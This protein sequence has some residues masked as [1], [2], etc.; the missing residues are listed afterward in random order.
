MSYE[1]AFK[2]YQTPDRYEQAIYRHSQQVRW[3][4]VLTCPCVNSITSQPQLNCTLC[5]GRGKIFKNP[6]PFYI[7]Q[8]AVRHD[9]RGRVWP[10]KAPIVVG[11]AACWKRTVAQTLASPQ[12]TDGTYVQLAA[13]Y[14]RP[15]EP[16]F[17]DYK[18]S[19][20]I[21]VSKENSTVYA[22]NTL[23][24]TAPRFN[25]R[26]KA[27]EGSINSVTT[28]YNLTRKLTYTVTSFLKEFIYL[29]A[30]ASWQAS[31]VLEVTYTYLPPFNFMINS[32]SAQRRYEAGY[33]LDKAD[34]TI[35][36]PY[37]AQIAPNDL[38]TS[39]SAEIPAFAVVDPTYH[40]GN[41]EIS[42]Y[43]DLSRITNCISA[44]GTEYTIGT[45]LELRGRNEIKWLTTKPTVKYTVHFM[46]HPTFV[47]L[48]TYD[49]ARS[50]ESK[51]FVNRV[52][53]MMYDKV[54]REVNF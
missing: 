35:A 50:S 38:I 51:S 1:Q 54:T 45:N 28:V 25:Y 14:I 39:L 17:I 46:Y 44:A 27:F 31:D 49:T 2:T 18:F 9:Y 16:L 26:G 20:I 47:A 13:P 7:E 41:D 36:A 34:A 43:F 29:S 12:P 11:S 32:I 24:V 40:A 6:G 23:Q 53:A 4:K 52:N 19:P 15:Y 10:K 5:K 37:W 33:V 21:S 22:T 3:V 42:D 30:M 48:T 8:E